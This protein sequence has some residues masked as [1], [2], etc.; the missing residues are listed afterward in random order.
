MNAPRPSFFAELQRRNVYKVGAMYAVAGWLLVQVVTQVLP[1]FDVS[2][3]GQRILVLIVVAGFPLALVLAW[4]F[5]LTPEGI[6]RT[7]DAS[8]ASESA[9]ALR[10]RHGMDR[11][12]NY[13]L[14]ALLVLAL[15][16]VVLERT[17]LR[18]G[19]AAVAANDKSI[20][21]LPF[22]NLSDDKANAY[23]AE[24]M[25]DEI[26][27]RLAKIGSLRV[28]SR[29]STV[30]YASSPDNI[31]QIAQQLGVANIL[32]GS[33]Q[34]AGNKV[35]VNVQ[36]IRASGDS[37]LWAETYD[38]S[39]DDVFGV[40]GE[41]AATIA[42]TLG[43][44]LTGAARQEVTA[45]PTRNAAAYDAYLHGVALYR[46][47][48]F[49]AN[50]RAATHAFE[51]AV[52][53]DPGFAQ[54]W[55]LLARGYALLVFFGDDA[56]PERRA[57]TLHAL[58]QAERL[59]PDTLETRSA[60]AYYTYRVQLDYDE[61]LRQFQAL[62]QRWPNDVEVLTV[63]SYIL[64]RQDR[65]AEAESCV[66]QALRL[67]PLNIQLYKLQ[68]ISASDN[69]RFDDAM[70]AL[71]RAQALAPDDAEIRTMRGN[72]LVAQGRLAE[73][74]S[75]LDPP[76]KLASED[77]GPYLALV[78]LQH[79]WKPAIAWLQ[80][81]LARPDPNAVAGDWISLRLALAD[82]RRLDGDA[83]ARVD[84]EAASKQAQAELERAPDNPQMRAVLASALAGLGDEKGALAQLD[85]V[86]RQVPESKDAMVGRHMLELRARLLLRFGHKEE[87][88]A[89]LRHLLTVAEQSLYTNVPLTPAMLR[90]DPDFDTLRGDPRFQELLDSGQA[91][92]AAP[93]KP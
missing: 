59:A 68:A 79:N 93:D 92:A 76:P 58:E 34:K 74:A 71:D 10:Q 29:T 44:E 30:R 61:A 72:Y 28:I 82:L 42:D 41:V 83:A 20:A 52:A 55:A 65:L 50:F 75:L 49:N 5:D 60:R 27:T 86:Q 3:L 24:G 17:L 2:A 84:Y 37:H 23:F 21:V 66:Q 25:Q 7:P 57:A 85:L 90:L 88:L 9:A 16:Y 89:I 56:S 80:G 54:A 62:H 22:A 8:G 13:V 69:R 77:G 36:L 4:L 38:R 18:G 46:K 78:T 26:L 6:V 91:A 12:L 70:K 31:G 11:K 48:F 81:V 67:D 53:A 45:A 14:G 15:G 1:V 35:R 47:G 51:E 87:A 19:A 64:A 43:A 63:M 32:E 39:L 40:Q 33:V 73:A